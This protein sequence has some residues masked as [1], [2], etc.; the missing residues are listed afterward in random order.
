MARA[1]HT[2][3]KLIIERFCLIHSLLLRIVS[4]ELQNFLS[5]S[6]L[7]QISRIVILNQDDPVISFLLDL[8]T[9]KNGG[10]KNFQQ[11]SFLISLDLL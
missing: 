5:A 9:V 2:H 4:N 10:I 8:E 6:E 11:G 1:L 3:A 7:T